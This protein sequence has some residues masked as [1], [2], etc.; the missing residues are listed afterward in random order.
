[1]HTGGIDHLHTR[2]RMYQNLEEYPHPIK[3]KRR[4]DYAMAF[5]GLAA[6]I[7]LIPQAIEIFTTRDVH[8][9][10]LTTWLVLGSINF[11]W[12][13]YGLVHREPPISI[14]NFCSCL[15]N[16]TIA[17]GVILYR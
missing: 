13:V 14:A 6:P 2:K 15:L 17:L 10:S 8:S 11:L 9:F 5:V 1:M 4:F 16:L 3:W 7:A 12:G